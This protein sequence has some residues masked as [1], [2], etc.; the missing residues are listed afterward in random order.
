MSEKVVIL[1][2]EFTYA[3]L[4]ERFSLPQNVTIEGCHT[5][6][7]DMD[8]VEYLEK[9]NAVLSFGVFGFKEQLCK[10][11][12]SDSLIYENP[13]LIFNRNYTTVE[14]LI[15]LGFGKKQAQNYYDG[16]RET[17]KDGIPF[18]LV[19]KMLNIT[20]CGETIQEE[21]TKK[22]YGKEYSTFGLNKEIWSC[23]E[24]LGNDG[25]IHYILGKLKD[26]GYTTFNPY[27]EVVLTSENIK[28]LLTG[29]PKEH[30]FKTKAEFLSKYPNL[31]EVKKMSDADM[32]ITDS[33]ESKSSK[34]KDAEKLNKQIKTY[35]DKF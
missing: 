13:L 19:I 14:K 11:L 4:E 21:F 8:S 25:T 3:E 30:G 18:N 22:W 20:G 33:L 16:L 27:K 10:L 15:E 5:I 9:L 1:G 28:V 24:N 23:L 31:I 2:K 34:M 26:Y 6:S 35:A 29:S 17:F 7:N 32:L 12:I